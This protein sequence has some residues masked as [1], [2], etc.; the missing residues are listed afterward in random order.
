MSRTTYLIIL[1]I[2]ILAIAYAGYSFLWGSEKVVVPVNGP[3]ALEL[4]KT[5]PTAAAFI[6]ENF[7]APQDRIER[8]ALTW[9]QGSDT[10]RWEIEI[11]EALCGCGLNDSDGVTIIKASVDPYKGTI[12]NLSTRKGVPEEQIKREACEKGC[13]IGSSGNRPSPN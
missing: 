10:Y 1:S 5:E 11:Q 12:L 8:V 9:D 7:G 6:K 13:H 2:V 3:K 4:V